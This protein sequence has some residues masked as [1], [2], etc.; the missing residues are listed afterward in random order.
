MMESRHGETRLMMILTFF[1]FIILKVSPSSSSHSPC[2]SSSSS[3][4]D[5]ITSDRTLNAESEER[6]GPSI[7]PSKQVRIYLM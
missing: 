6:M 3:S 5:G 2:I 1:V 7:E 4:G